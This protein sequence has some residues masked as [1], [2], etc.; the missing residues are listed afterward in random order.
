MFK[1][2]HFINSV[3]LVIKVAAT[4]IKY[5]VCSNCFGNVD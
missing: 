4:I 3:K 5:S 1:M 2:L